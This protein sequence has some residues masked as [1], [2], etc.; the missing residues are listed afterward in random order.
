MGQAHKVCLNLAWSG[1]KQQR[2]LLIKKGLVT[3]LRK[4]AVNRGR[5]DQ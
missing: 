5:S 2:P 1:K 4:H 3:D